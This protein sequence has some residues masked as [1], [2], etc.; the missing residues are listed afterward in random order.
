[1][2]RSES[3]V[4]AVGVAFVACIVFFSFELQKP[5]APWIRRAAHNPAARLIA[6]AILI[7]LGYVDPLLAIL[8][9]I[10]VFFWVADVKLLSANSF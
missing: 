7:V 6:G 9:L 4:T 10:I 8:W 5:Y 1:M 2:N 3:L